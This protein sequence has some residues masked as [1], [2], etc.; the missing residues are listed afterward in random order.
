M[1]KLVILLI[2]IIGMFSCKEEGYHPQ[3]CDLIFQI[4]ETTDFSKAITDATAQHDMIKIDHVAMVIIEDGKPHVIEASGKDGVI[5]VPLEN[6]LKK[7]PAGYI[8]KRVKAKISSLKVINNAKQHLGEPYDWS[9]LP[10]NGKMYCSELIYESFVDDKGQRIFHARP[11]NF[12]NEKGEMPQFWIDLFKK[13]GED[14]P[15]GVLGTNPDR[16]SVV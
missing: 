5:L 10:N 16:K 13:L 7:M 15:E 12:R 14:I 8:V 2:L 1:Q 4:A 11:M 6:F 3:D 9:Y